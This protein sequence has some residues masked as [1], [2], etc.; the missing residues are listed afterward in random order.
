MPPEETAA[1]SRPAGP[2][3]P[4]APVRWL[5]ALL[6]PTPVT[7]RRAALACVI[8][9]VGI[10][11]TGAAVRLSASGLGCPSWPE[12]TKSSLFA[13]H[14]RGDPMVHTWIEFGNRVLGFA[15]MATAVVAVVVAWRLRTG[16]GRQRRRDLLL[17][18]ALQPVGVLAQAAIGGVVVLTELDPVW[19]TVHFL[20]SAAVVAAAVILHVRAAEGTGPARWLVRPELR[21]LGVATAGVTLAMLAAGTVVTGSGPLA[22]A[23]DV[24]RYHLPR[25]AV[26]MFHADVGWVLGGAVFALALGLRLTGAPPR[27]TRLGYTLLALIGL[28]GLLGYVQYFSGLP[29]G[30]VWVHESSAMLIWVVVLQ[31][32][33]A[34][35]DRGP[36]EPASP[37]GA[38]AGTPVAGAGGFA[39]VT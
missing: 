23:S 35:R 29:A 32:A 24:P 19:V 6:H 8:A 4:R 22:G 31:L 1:P 12:C 26:T 10:V 14:T 11:A 16:P 3:L 21:V 5:A 28:Q 39:K 36:I 2:G 34:M 9:N 30:L 27:L 38:L 33:F 18:A 37:E 25:V 7:M 20:I 17:L 15:V 13:A